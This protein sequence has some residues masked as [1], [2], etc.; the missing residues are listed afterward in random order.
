M[1]ASS[2][3]G[4]I[5][6][7]RV[8]LADGAELLADVPGHDS[9]RLAPGVTVTVAFVDRPVLVSASDLEGAGS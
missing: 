3:R 6:R 4:S 5:A 7:L 1:V 9:V 8:Q 2:F